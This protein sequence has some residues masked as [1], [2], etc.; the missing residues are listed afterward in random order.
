MLVTLR[1]EQAGTELLAGEIEL[2]G[3][4]WVKLGATGH[5]TKRFNPSM[6]SATDPDAVLVSLEERLL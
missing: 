1:D 4:G 2:L 6:V 5:L 3:D